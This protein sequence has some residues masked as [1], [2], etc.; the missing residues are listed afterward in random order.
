MQK[1]LLVTLLFIGCL[2]HAFAQFYPLGLNPNRLQWRQINTEK[3]RLVFPAALQDKANRTATLLHYLYDSSAH[4]IGDRKQKVTIYLQNQNTIPNGFVALGPFR[5]EFYM[6]APQ[7]GFLGSGNWADLLAVHE[8]RHVLQNTNAKQG[9][10]KAVSW[11]FGQNGWAFM[12]GMAFPRWFAEGDA[13]AME[14]ALSQAGRGRLPDFHREYRAL[15]TQNRHYN[16]EKASAGSLRDF[17]PSHYHLGY[18]LTAYA[19]R[20]YGES[21]WREVVEDAAKYKGLFFPLSRNLKKRTG[22]STPQLYRAAMQEMDSLWEAQLKRLP[23]QTYQPIPTPEKPVFTRYRN[24][25]FLNDSTLVVLKSSLREIPQFYEVT[26][27]GK[28]QF[29]GNAGFNVAFNRVHAVQ[30]ETIFWAEVSYHERWAGTTYSILKKYDLRKKLK[31]KLTKAS[32][33]F[34]L[35]V[36]PDANRLV[37]VEAN[38]AMDYLLKILATDDG[39]VL[40]AFPNPEGYFYTFPRW[41]AEGTHIVT[42]VQKDNRNALARIDVATGNTTLLSPWV[43]EQMV[44]PFEKDGIVYFSAAFSPVQNLYAVRLSDQ[45]LLQV[46]KSKDDVFFGDISP[47]GQ[48][49]VFTEFNAMGETIYQVPVA[50]NT[51]QKLAS[52]PSVS[53]LHADILAEQEGGDQLD[54]LEVQTFEQSRFSKL[55]GL[56]NIHSI[57]PFLFHPNY[58]IE[59]QSDNTFTTFS[60]VG[61]ANYNAN[62]ENV[63]YYGTVRYGGFFPVLELTASTLGNRERAGFFI[64]QDISQGDTTLFGDFYLRNWKENDLALGITLPFNLMQGIHF[65]DLVLS[66]HYHFRTVDHAPTSFRFDT[67][68]QARDGSFNAL[69]FGVEFSRFRTT[70]PRQILPRFG[71]LFQLNYQTTVGTETNKGSSLLLNAALYWPGL[72]RTHSFYVTGAYRQEQFTNPY[73]FPDNFFYPRGYESSLVHDRIHRLSLNYSFPLW[74]PDVA[75][76]PLAFIQRIKMNLFYDTATAA[77]DAIQAGSLPNNTEFTNIRGEISASSSTYRSFGAELTFDFRAFRLLDVELGA[78]YSRLLDTFGSR[79]PNHFDFILIRIEP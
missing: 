18:Y 46:T 59:L 1:K 16:Y 33:Y 78:R 19:R 54:D 41:N 52:Y 57:Q 7:L 28:E 2:G 62:E 79:Q 38:E 69:S 44:R 55:T 43:I 64:E 71:Q 31:T 74:Y 8:Y 4:T 75:L 9:V 32:R 26:L 27:S 22:L 48:K 63:S 76:G 40:K 3:I 30:N 17:V 47:N 56:L 34:A 15:R 23:T 60:A 5:S 65:A 45:A 13:I 58:R 25:R 20:H 37:T 70:A 39:S 36:S 24:P 77:T 51:W 10:S 61:G 68:E 14:T 49:L 35:D 67:E 12:R 72:F 73:L 21:I 11:L 66:S 29:I 50:P 6:N 42:V 53:Y